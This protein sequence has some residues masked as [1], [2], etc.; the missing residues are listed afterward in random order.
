V[1]HEGQDEVVF[2]ASNKESSFLVV[3]VEEV[4]AEVGKSVFV[5]WGS[6]ESR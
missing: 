4:V 2:L 1:E 5:P 6:E 3:V